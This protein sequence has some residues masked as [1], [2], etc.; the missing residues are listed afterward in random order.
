M[1]TRHRMVWLLAYW[2]LAGCSVPE[3]VG[4][5]RGAIDAGAFEPSSCETF[6]CDLPNTACAMQDDA[7]ACICVPGYSENEA[8]KCAQDPCTL[9]P[10][11]TENGK[12]ICTPHENGTFTCSCDPDYFDDNGAGGCTPRLVSPNLANL[13]GMALEGP[14]STYDARFVVV[15][16]DGKPI[17]DA[18]I[19]L[20][21][22][23]AEDAPDENENENESESGPQV[24][25]TDFIGRAQIPAL[26]LE[27]EDWIQI[28]KPGFLTITRRTSFAEAGGPN[29][30]RILLA[31]LPRRQHV[32]AEA[33]GSISDGPLRVNFPP[34]A[35]VSN[36]DNALRGLVQVRLTSL[37]PAFADDRGEAFGPLRGRLLDGRL[38]LLHPLSMADVEISYLPSAGGG[39]RT[40][41]KLAADLG[42]TLALR[43]PNDASLPLG[44]ELPLF[45]YDPS[46]RTWNQENT[47]EVRRS[48]HHSDADSPS[49]ALECV[50]LVTHFSKW[51]VAEPA[52]SRCI[53]FA[54]NAIRLPSHL[55]LR[56]WSLHFS[57][58]TSV[59]GIQSCD[60]TAT[61]GATFAP[62]ETGDASQPRPLGRFYALT[63]TRV[64]VGR[65]GLPTLRGTLRNRLTGRD[66]PFEEPLASLSLEALSERP[67]IHN[68]DVFAD[69]SLWV[70]SGPCERIAAEIILGA[71]PAYADAD[72]DGFWT[73]TET[74]S[75][76]RAL[77]DCD[78]A[79]PTTHPRAYEIPCDGH[80]SRCR[81]PADLFTEPVSLD[82]FVDTPNLSAW[83][84][85]SAYITPTKEALW[86]SFCENRCAVP[87][88]TE[89]MG[90]PYDDDCD[91]LTLD[92]D[93]DG[94]LGYAEQAGLEENAA[95][96]PL[97]LADDW[98]CDDHSAAAHPGSVE[99]PSNG[100]DEDCDGIV[101]D[102]DGDGWVRKGT[103]TFL[104]Y[105]GATDDGALRWG[106]CNDNDAQI[107]PDAAPSAESALAS[108]FVQGNNGVITRTENFCQLLDEE[109]NFNAYA[110]SLMQDRNCDGEVTDA[111]G[112]G[113]TL[114]GHTGLGAE[115]AYDCNDF[116]PRVVVEP[117]Y[118]SV[119]P[120]PGGFR[121]GANVD[122][123]PV[124][125]ETTAGDEVEC[126]YTKMVCVTLPD[127]QV[128]NRGECAP[129]PNAHQCEAIAGTPTQCIL[130]QDNLGLCTPPGWQDSLPPRPTDLGVRWGPCDFTGALPS[131]P[132]GTLCAGPIDVW[133][134]EYSR[135]LE[136]AAAEAGEGS[137]DLSLIAPELRGMCFPLCEGDEP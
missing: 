20:V 43:L 42:A 39:A 31:P 100:I 84:E 8:G 111:D 71:T 21:S 88:P 103:D 134:E 44:T 78:D 132:K 92:R 117:Q 121:P 7:P 131:C 87:K 47:C 28:K 104:V 65:F 35:F 76:V 82:D 6:V 45:S 32:L 17:Y 19:S 22:H 54:P 95:E 98:D 77:E 72:G 24:W 94:F 70:E 135:V 81:G 48:A 5:P 16:P 52:P 40:R 136:Q 38:S 29:R 91:G 79:D 58:C 63:S 10:C 27:Q 99:I 14:R 73:R 108:Y 56:N 53:Y 127:E 34:Y 119:T 129:K 112:D 13:S 107:S 51:L 25:R 67:E 130:V 69:E 120:P 68:V 18:E 137:I 37:S 126:G 113:W 23:D 49:E 80:T 125:C 57:N 105:A 36:A 2:M 114:R 50:A 1:P 62:E 59:D 102:M 90:N 109:G 64:T 115:R 128:Q 110:W 33:G 9:D 61:L 15:R 12:S 30:Q 122:G 83:A 66:V 75:P 97:V 26:Q 96:P 133:T 46:R 123:Y 93:G 74:S 3:S 118:V 11:P 55:E 85:Q 89:I 106:D 60:E 4:P 101:L 86:S 116:D 41:A 124:E